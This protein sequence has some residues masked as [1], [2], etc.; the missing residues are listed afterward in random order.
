MGVL[1]VIGKFISDLEKPQSHKD[2]DRW[3][4]MV[5]GKIFVRG[6]YDLLHKS[7]DSLTNTKRYVETSLLPDLKF[8]CRKTR[9]EFYVECKYRSGLVAGRIE[10]AKD[11]Q[12]KRYREIKEPVYIALCYDDLNNDTALYYV[13]PL[14]DIKYT[15]LYPSAIKQYQV[16]LKCLKLFK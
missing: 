5:E 1:N 4:K 10:W 6:E 8:R 14:K 2:G 12:L 3:E 9:K 11:Y 16:E 13:I 15:G 7:H